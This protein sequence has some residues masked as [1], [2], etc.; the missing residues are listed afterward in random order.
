MRM[1]LQLVVRMQ[2]KHE[3]KCGTW[4]QGWLTDAVTEAEYGLQHIVVPVECKPEEC[5][6][7]A[8]SAGGKGAASLCRSGAPKMG[9]LWPMLL[10]AAVDWIS[11][12]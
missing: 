1:S 3:A 12:A 8:T 5:T 6:M 7:A 4:G 10:H 9:V 2:V 11:H